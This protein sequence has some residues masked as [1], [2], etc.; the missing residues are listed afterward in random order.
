MM[1]DD[2]EVQKFFFSRRCQNSRGEN[3]K[4]PLTE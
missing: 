3:N 2:E 4:M 1:N